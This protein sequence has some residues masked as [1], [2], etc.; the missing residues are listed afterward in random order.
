MP[1]FGAQL[2]GDLKTILAEHSLTWRIQNWNFIKFQ[3]AQKLHP[4]AN[5]ELEY[6]RNLIGS[7]K[8]E[9]SVFKRSIQL[10][11]SVTE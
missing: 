9:Y 11:L 6:F 8:E 10:G 2:T 4:Y 7:D 5:V 3:K 1:D